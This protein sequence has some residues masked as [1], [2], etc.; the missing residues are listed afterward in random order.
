M[1]QSV[2]SSDLDVMLIGK[3]GVGKSKTGNTLLNRNAFSS[4]PSM[5]SETMK[6][7]KELSLLEDGRKL[8]VVDTPGVGDTRCTLN[9]GQE[10]FVAAIQEAVL[11]N[12][13]GYHALLVVIR[14]GCRFTEEDINTI[15]Y[16]KIVFGQDFVQKHCV[17]VMTYGDN[18]TAAKEDGEITVPFLEWCKQQ[19][20]FKSLFLEVQERV[21]L[22]NNRGTHQEKLQ[23]RK[24]LVLMVDRL[25]SGGLRYTDV[26]FAEARKHQE[27]LIS[28]H[29]ISKSA[30]DVQEELSLILYQKDQIKARNQDIDKQV[31]ELKRLEDQ[32]IALLQKVQ[33]ETN[34]TPDLKRLKSVLSC[35]LLQLEKELFCI[36]VA[37]DL[38]NKEQ[39]GL[40]RQAAELESQLAVQ[41]K[42]AD[43][44]N[45]K[46]NKEYKEARDANNE[47]W[48]FKTLDAV[49]AAACAALAFI[50]TPIKTAVSFFFRR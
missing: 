33:E 22:F 4:K 13:A 19:R 6:S 34:S 20:P 12:P 30:M 18:F 43:E 32:G 24:E 36:D 28:E 9:E 47:T 7:Q 14:F 10:L 40:K 16:L 3:T 2:S 5:E 21:V 27:Q 45:K 1:G 15:T 49:K 42:E 23:Q 41:Q 46:L 44:L 48:A 35:A 17:I 8:C 31:N 26:N 38:K 11:Y 29:K 50:L 25:S 37:K 39:T